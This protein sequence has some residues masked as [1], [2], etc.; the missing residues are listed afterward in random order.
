M[1]GEGAGI[2]VLEEYEH[3]LNR[4]AKIYAEIIGYGQN[5]DAYHITAPSPGGEG[6]SESMRIA[7]ED[8][9]I[10]P[11][12]VDYINTH[13]TSTPLGDIAELDAIKNVFG[14]AVYNIN[15]SSSKSMTGHLLGAAGA[16]EPIACVH[17]IRTESSLLPLISRRKTAIDYSLNLTLNTAQKRKVRV[18]VSNNFG[19]GGHNATI[20]FAAPG[21]VPFP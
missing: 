3:A 5:A 11:D 12:Q 7:L 9:G 20:V 19:F 21:F 14:D 16:V 15:L 18:A 1:I 13:G 10:S 6:A 4:G 17:A 8:A 2:L